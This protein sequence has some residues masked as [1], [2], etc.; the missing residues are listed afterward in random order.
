[1]LT[2]CEH[3]LHALHALTCCYLRPHRN[4]QWANAALVVSVGPED[5]GHLQHKDVLAGVAMQQEMERAAAVMGGGGFVAPVQRVTDFMAGE[6]S[7]GTL[8]SS[9]YR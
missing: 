3:A 2:C 8:P 6:L 1:M 7:T 5:W 4:S 9:S